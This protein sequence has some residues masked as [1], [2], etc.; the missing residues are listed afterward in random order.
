MTAAGSGILPRGGRAPAIPALLTAPPQERERA[1]ARTL[2]AMA[3][4]VSEDGLASVTVAQLTS[5]AR[6]SR[7]RFYELFGDREGCFLD[8]FDEALALAGERVLPHW[9]KDDNW[10]RRLRGGLLALLA[11]FDE[12]PK[13]ARLCLLYALEAG[14]R[15]LDRRRQVLE[16]L[17][18]A[19][20]DGR[21]A[22]PANMQPGPWTADGVV[23]AAL[24]LIQAR[25]LESS[26]SP[27]TDLFR[28][29]MYMLVLPYLGP[30]AAN[31]E[32]SRP[33]PPATRAR[34]DFEGTLNVLRA[35]ESRLTYRT[36]R[37]LAA[38]AA[39]PGMN[40]CDVAA[41]ADLQ[42]AGQ[43]S[44][45]LARLARV[46]LV[47]NTKA[48][49]GRTRPNAWTLTSRGAEVERATRNLNGRTRPSGLG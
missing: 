28:P 24:A 6:V 42:D 22:A 18:G 30:G 39:A 5:R 31:R 29:A 2:A 11:F 49:E 44:K 37:V 13:L 46:G 12:E 27:L 7:M 1:R 35:L 14:P 40:N 41:A 16:M 48:D 20:D 10:L 3:E 4:L 34:R 45:L 36:I 23:G 43:A 19:V 15:A 21:C 17:A 47:R 33:L 9:E 26:P 25:V 8:T 32:L 38:I